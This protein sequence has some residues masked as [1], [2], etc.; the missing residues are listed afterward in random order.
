VS[1]SLICRRAEPA[2]HPELVAIWRRAVDATHDFLEPGEAE[3]IEVQVRDEVLAALDMTVAVRDGELVGWIAVDGTSVEALFVDPAAHRRGVG[4]ALLD[5]LT[6]SMPVV[7]LDV[8]E[9]NPTAVAFYRA[10]GFVP[11]GRSEH[12]EDGRPYPLLHMR[13]A[14]PGQ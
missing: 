7:T 11:T 3:R 8:N 4:S 5:A 10:R 2:D 13:R 9:Q 14:A 6:A 12:D 1:G